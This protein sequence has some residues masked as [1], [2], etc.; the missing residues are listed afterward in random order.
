MLK[1]LRE[2]L[3]HFILIGIALFVG[4]GLWE[5]SVSKSD[6]TIYISQAE[7]QRQAVIFASENQRQPNDEDLFGLIYAHAEE[8]ILMREAARLGLDDNDTIIRRRMA[9]K[10][11]FMLTEDTPP[12]LPSEEEL[13]AWFEENKAQFTAPIQRSFTHVYFSPGSHKDVEQVAKDALGTVSDENWQTLGDP[14]IEQ[15]TYSAMDETSIARRFGNRFASDLFALSTTTEWQGPI[16][17]A[18]GMHLIRI[19]GHSARSTPDFGNSRSEIE[20]TWQ[21]QALRAANLKRL[22]D[23]K[24]SYIVEVESTEE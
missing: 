16:P 2:P 6:H 8:Q 7:I 12:D 14:F 11:R 24:D 23:L 4:H 13:K 18:F 1:L 15:N 22:E 9:Q 5:R 20:K 3:V 19:N 17:S 10:M 21:E